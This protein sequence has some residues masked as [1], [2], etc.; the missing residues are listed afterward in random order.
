V[1]LDVG[2]GVV[3]DCLVGLFF[4]GYAVSL[5]SFL[6]ALFFVGFLCVWLGFL[7]VFVEGGCGCLVVWLWWVCVGRFLLLGFVVGCVGLCLC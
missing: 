5:V 1:V 7:L 6:C 4:Y 3:F 2:L